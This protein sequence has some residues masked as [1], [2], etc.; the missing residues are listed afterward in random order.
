MVEPLRIGVVGA[1]GRMGQMILRQIAETPGCAVG[2]ATEGPGHPSLGRDAGLVAGLSELGIAIGDDPAPVARPK[3][4]ARAAGKGAPKA[5]TAPHP[6][7]APVE[8]KDSATVT[9]ID[10]PPKRRK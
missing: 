1:G 9:R 10:T 7:A 3:P 2:G 8:D 6:M 4:I 5:A